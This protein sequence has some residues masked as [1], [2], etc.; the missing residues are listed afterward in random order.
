MY[1]EVAVAYFKT[2]SQ[3]L[4]GGNEE[5]HE[6]LSYDSRRSKKGIQDTKQEW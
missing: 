1:K 6:N 4:L 2:P 3:N 5:D